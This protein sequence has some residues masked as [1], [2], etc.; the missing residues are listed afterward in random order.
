MGLSRTE[1][2]ER[3]CQRLWGNRPGWAYLAFGHDP[4]WEAGRYT[5]SG[6]QPEFY[7]WPDQ[8]EQ[9][10]TAAID[11]AGRGD[12]FV[13]PIL[14]AHPSPTALSRGKPNLLASSWAWADCDRKVS[15]RP[16]VTAI[17]SVRIVGISSG[18]GHHVYAQLPEPVDA[19][20]VSDLN[21]RLADEL[22]A[23]HCWAPAGL[24]RL[25]GSFNWK[26]SPPVLVRRVW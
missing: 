7:P 16:V 4:H 23:D 24:L 10:A 9:L 22:G 15:T 21:H 3:H 19:P 6:W 20:T 2:A 17:S 18:R 11:F 14:R 25:P 1:L 13:A 5:H 26:T 8:C 12:V